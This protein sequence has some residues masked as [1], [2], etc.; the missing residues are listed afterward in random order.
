MP[1][2]PNFN[3]SGFGTDSVGK[4][5][6]PPV[7]LNRLGSGS[8]VAS[9]DVVDYG[10]SSSSSSSSLHSSGAG[11]SLHSNSLFRQFPSINM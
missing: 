3:R 5:T 8:P 1:K 7:G 6:L 4:Y 10:D 9:F 11:C 2:G